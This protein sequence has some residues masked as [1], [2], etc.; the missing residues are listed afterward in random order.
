MLLHP[1]H[2]L[3]LSRARAG[4]FSLAYSLSR[5]LSH[6][7]TR[8]FSLSLSP[9]LALSLSQTLSLSR[10]LRQALHARL[11]AAQDRH[12]E[13]EGQAEML[14]T[15]IAAERARGVEPHPLRLPAVVF[16]RDLTG[17]L[18]SSIAAQRA[19]EV[20]PL[21]LS[22]SISM[23]LSFFRPLARA[24]SL[25][26]YR[27]GSG[28]D[29]PHQH[30]CRAHEGGEAPPRPAPPCLPDVI[31]VLREVCESALRPSERGG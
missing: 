11:D 28:G 25:S 8:S 17:M 14:R 19:R 21:A 15:S 5:S 27:H 22:L 24:L 9:S 29:A 7:H 10:S 1:G 2:C 23:D 16:G 20:A 30:C 31:K 6:T 12:R 18:R 4:L 3:S 26:L 13:N